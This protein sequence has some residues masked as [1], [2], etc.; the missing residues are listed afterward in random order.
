MHLWSWILVWAW[1]GSPGASWASP[2][3][4]DQDKKFKRWV[5]ELRNP[6]AWLRIRALHR[7]RRFHEYQDTVV[8]WHLQALQDPI[9]NVRLHAVAYLKH[10]ARYHKRVVPGLIR[11]LGDSHVKVRIRAAVALRLFQKHPAVFIYRIRKALHDSSPDVRAQTALS[12]ADMGSSVKMV[13]RDLLKMATHPPLKPRKSA[14]YALGHIA[15]DDPN[16]IQKVLP[17][18][19]NNL[20]AKNAELRETAARA[21]GHIGSPARKLATALFFRLHDV[22]PEV[23]RGTIWALMQMGPLP[24]RFSRTLL[25]SLYDKDATVRSLAA[26]A[27]GKQ[28]NP[29]IPSLLKMLRVKEAEVRHH[30]LVAL[31]LM[32]PRA[33]KASQK[34]VRRRLRD[35]N[36]SVRLAAAQALCR[37]QCKKAT[38]DLIRRLRRDRSPRVREETAQCIWRMGEKAR[39]AVP[40][41]ARLIYKDKSNEVRVAAIQTLA[42]IRMKRW[43]ITA[44]RRNLSDDSAEVRIAIAKALLTFGKQARRAERALARRLKRDSDVRIRRIA[45]QALT[46]I[47]TRRATQAIARI[48]RKQDEELVLEALK[49]LQTLRP[50]SRQTLRALTRALRSQNSKVRTQAAYAL[51]RVGKVRRRTRRKL[52]KALKPLHKDPSLEVRKAAAHASRWLG[53]PTQA[54]QKQRRY[55]PK[56]HQ[57]PKATRKPENQKKLR[58]E[59]PK[60]EKEKE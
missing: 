34:Q 51:A 5:D 25:E 60:K 21:L 39:K 56:P 38:W 26:Q 49:A 50:R 29:I 10:Q 59:M 7:I 9:H 44:F 23:R 18:L 36:S 27:L 20:K 19:Q 58:K 12:I 57:K 32:G 24:Y 46:Q 1:L 52:R 42:R 14:L 3:N 16:A 48:V 35:D 4:P 31:G 22:A 43:S 2:E 11:A 30:A 28:D 55:K 47:G 8:N 54:A 33:A 15:R 53:S 13:L 37:M 6:D 40:A 17:V 41:L 45:L